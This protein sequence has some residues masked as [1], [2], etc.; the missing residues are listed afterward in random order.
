MKYKVDALVS[1]TG[2][3]F[4][5]AVLTA[6]PATAAGADLDQQHC[7]VNIDTSRIV[8]AATEDALP[9]AV[10]EA[11]GE[12]I[13]Y[14]EEAVGR[15]AIEPLTT[16]A[17]GTIYSYPNYGGRSYLM[18]SSA[19]CGG[20]LLHGVSDLGSIGWNDDIDS[21]KSAGSC[22]TKIWENT[23]FS[24]TSYGYVI[25]STDVGS[26]KNRASSIRWG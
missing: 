17:L 16:Y 26:M 19:P 10:F 3:L 24:G 13:V 21:F 8:C 20:A 14:V 7:A 25:N 9:D 18:T 23:S 4:A 11:T 5:V 6:A 15:T 12:A 22:L 2:M 1:V